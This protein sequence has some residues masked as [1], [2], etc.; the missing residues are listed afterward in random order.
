VVEAKINSA[1]TSPKH[2]NDNKGGIMSRCETWDE[3]EESVQDKHLPRL[4]PWSKKIVFAIF[5]VALLL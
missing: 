3:G 4:K 2:Q 5:S 1:T